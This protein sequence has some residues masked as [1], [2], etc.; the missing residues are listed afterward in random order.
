MKKKE[1]EHSKLE[2]NSDLTLERYND[3]VEKF[4]KAQTRF[5]ELYD[6]RVRF[7]RENTELKAALDGYK[8]ALETERKAS[9][10]LVKINRKGKQINFHLAQALKTIYD[11]DTLSA[12]MPK[13][14]K[15]EKQS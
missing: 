5:T 12:L 4:D 9:A 1:P 15:D 2:N 3:L 14:K 6:E 13:P 10:V 8:A 7:G 11:K